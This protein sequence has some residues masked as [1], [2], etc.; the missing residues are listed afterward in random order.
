MTVKHIVSLP[1]K[2]VVGRRDALNL[3]EQKNQQIKYQEKE[4]KHAPIKW[5]VATLTWRHKERYT[6]A[7][8]QHPIT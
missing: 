7:T 1:S 2:C 8:R 5:K 4:T 3:P 6:K